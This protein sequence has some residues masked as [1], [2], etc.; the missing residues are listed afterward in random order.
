[1]PENE[2]IIMRNFFS[3]LTI[4][5]LAL[6]IGCSGGGLPTQVQ[7]DTKPPYWNDSD[8]VQY[9]KTGRGN[10]EVHWGFASDE[11]N[12][13]VHYLVYMDTDDNPFDQVPIMV[14]EN[15]HSYKFDGLVNGQ[16][17]WFGVRSTDSATPP[18]MDSNTN[19]MMTSPYNQGWVVT[20]GGETSDELVGIVV[21]ENN[22]V[23]ACGSYSGTSVFGHSSNDSFDIFLAKYNPNGELVWSRTWG[24]TG[25]DFGTAIAIDVLTETLHVSGVY[26]SE[27]GP[28]D[29]DPSDA[30][31]QKPV[32][33]EMDCF[34]SKF[35]LNGNYIRALIW[36]GGKND[37]AGDVT[38]DESGNAYITGYFRMTVDFDPGSGSDEHTSIPG[39]VYTPVDV[40]VSKFDPDEN[41]IWTK[42]WGGTGKDEA[43]S[44]SARDGRIFIAGSVNIGGPDVPV[45]FDPGPGEHLLTTTEDIYSFT[46]CLDGDGGFL[47]ANVWG[48]NAN[49]VISDGSGGCYFVN[50]D[51]MRRYDSSG[52]LVWSH[53][54]EYNE[55]DQTIILDNQGNILLAHYPLGKF[56]SAG[57]SLWTRSLYANITKVAVDHSDNIIAGGMYTG[58]FTYAQSVIPIREQDSIAPP[59]DKNI[60]IMKLNP[61]G[62]LK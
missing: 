13:P 56:S 27:H 45:D 35:D 2:E 30:T 1:M 14:D 42:T 41:H 12:P 51:D 18:N 7:S 49:D 31:D 44:I 28:V 37:N 36:G 34:L 57:D 33:G 25:N 61:D 23:Y 50:F 20:F 46:S 32:Y 26:D 17:Y 22:N 5:L 47:W 40:Y 11:R 62:Y 9:L 60:F 3:S 10:V 52:N 58:D 54:S 4:S 55:Y 24:G 59:G 43:V 19:V 29:F 8:G 21:D 53:D 39:S 38:L 15:I 48:R 6:L 16:D